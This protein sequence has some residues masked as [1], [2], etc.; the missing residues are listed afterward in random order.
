[1][2]LWF[3]AL[4]KTLIT[5]TPINIVGVV[6][7]GL[8]MAKAYINIIPLSLF[9]KDLLETN[10]AEL[11]WLNYGGYSYKNILSYLTDIFTDIGNVEVGQIQE[12]RELKIMLQFLLY[13]N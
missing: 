7:D 9:A 13:Y 6:N 1:M 8:D 5:P 10:S 4:G 3:Y 2:L 11:L 12:D